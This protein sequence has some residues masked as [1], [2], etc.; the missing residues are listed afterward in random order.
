MHSNN[1]QFTSRVLKWFD[2]HGRHDLPWQSDITPYRVWVSEIMLQQ[3]Q[4]NTVIPYYL[5]FVDRFPTVEDLASADADQVLRCLAALGFDLY[6]EQLDDTETLL[7][8]LRE[9]REHLGGELTITLLRG[10][11]DPIEV[12]EMDAGRVRAAIEHLEGWERR[13]AAAS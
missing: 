8:G 1:L 9:F 4:V 10:I 11:G 6:H 2:K 5:R 3:T 13:S 12:H 7:D